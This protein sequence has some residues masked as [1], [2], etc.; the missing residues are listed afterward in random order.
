MNKLD[1]I[2]VMLVDDHTLLRE[3]LAAY[4]LQGYPDF[5]VV[6]QAADG[7]EAVELYARYQPDVVVMDVYMPYMDGFQ[8]T[9]EILRRFPQAR[10][11][12]LTGIEHSA[13]SHK[14]ELVG[15]VR[16]LDKRVVGDQLVEAIRQVHAGRGGENPKG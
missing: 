1:R 3:T 8:A 13:Y 11:I 10:I 2:N 4:L 9:A 5:G 16:F 14:A 7:R 6:L 15:A 12:I